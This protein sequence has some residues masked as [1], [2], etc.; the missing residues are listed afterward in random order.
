MAR[1]ATKPTTIWNDSD[2]DE[3]PDLDALISRKKKTTTQVQ[4]RKDAQTPRAKPTPRPKADGISAPATVRRRKLG[5]LTDNLLLRAW[6]PDSDREDGEENGPLHQEEEVVRPR[7]AR[8]E[9][10]TRT[11]KP[12]VVL[13][14]SPAGEDEAYVSAREEVTVIEEASIFDDTFHSCGS[15]GSEFEIHEDEDDDFVA[16]YIPRTLP[17]SLAKPQVNKRAGGASRQATPSIAL[18]EDDDE[19]DEPRLPARRRPAR[20]GQQPAEEK[21]KDLADTLSKLRL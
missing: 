11:I 6:K 20:K 1:T 14:S 3:F 2:D 13:P 5:P 12:A 10:R 4:A 17:T 15:D 19:D 21:P 7:R 18:E 9:L 8:V 16:E